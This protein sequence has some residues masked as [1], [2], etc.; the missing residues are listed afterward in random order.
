MFNKFLFDNCAVYE[1]MLKNIVEWGRPQ[2]AIWRMHIAWWTTKVTNTPSEYV[3]HIAFPKT[4]ISRTRLN[5]TLY[6]Q[7][8]APLV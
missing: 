7:Y 2:M 3:V 8:V 5:V 1:I 6:V 4:V